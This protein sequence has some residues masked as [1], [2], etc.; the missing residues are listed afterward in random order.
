MW[1]TVEARFRVWINKCWTGGGMQIPPTMG[2]RQTFWT[3]L[4]AF[5][6][7]LVLSSINEMFLD[8]TRSE[9]FLVIGPFGALMTLQYG[10][11]SAPASQPRNVVLG[12]VVAG[13]VSLC[14]TYIPEAILP[15]WVR[16]ALGPAF[17]IGAMVK[18]GIP[19]PP[20]G[21]HSVIW[22]AGEHD[23]SFYSIVVLCSIVSVVPA[24]LVNNMS[25]K[26][27]Y[28]IYWGY[29]PKLLHRNLF[30][31]EVKTKASQSL[32]VDDR[33]TGSV[34]QVEDSAR[35]SP[36]PEETIEEQPHNP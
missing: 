5:I 28:P 22:A 29:L 4:G 1:L 23:W 25:D 30:G 2:W 20:A 9:Y 26:R 21:A 14:F 33:S 31:P 35:T 13:A 10:L 32:L 3:I 12:Q 8:L 27:Q 6:G 34:P 15:V 16:Q 24:T 36:K 19:H 7:L 18:L 17:A 11:T